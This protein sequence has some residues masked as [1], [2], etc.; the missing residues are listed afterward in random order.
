MKL[1]NIAALYMQSPQ[2]IALAPASRIIY[3]RGM[4]ALKEFMDSDANKIT[5]PMIIDFKDRMY[6]KA[7]LCRSSLSAL[8]NILS[9]GYDR[10]L[11]NHNHASN[12]KYLPKTKPMPRWSDEDV[13]ATLKLAKPHVRAIILLALYTG[14]RRSDLYRMKW[15]QYDGECIRILQ[16]KTRK[17]LYIPVHPKLKIELERLKEERKPSGK[18]HISPYILTNF[19]GDPWT[20]LAMTYAVTEAAK[21]AGVHDR[22]LH[23]LRKTTAAK[24]A[25]I[26]CPPH[27]IAA[28]TGHST[29]KEI[30]NYTAEADQI[31][32]AKEA[33]ER[34]SNA[35]SSN[36]I[37]RS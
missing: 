24:L 29:L 22:T 6:G 1:K 18:K 26:G 31:R 12:M 14:Q 37:V 20:M 23:G 28:I 3:S 7:G 17:L 19:H 13:D 25:E 36:N 32:M 21:K 10:G 27:L 35:D 5:R 34:W 8:N 15:E 4:E 2:W 11:C 16:Q 30:M 9:Y 33:M